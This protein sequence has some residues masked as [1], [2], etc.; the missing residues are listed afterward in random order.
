MNYIEKGI[1][2]ISDYRSANVNT[3]GGKKTTEN[4]INMGLD[5]VGCEYWLKHGVS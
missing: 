2:K 5:V 3:H 1:I 4:R